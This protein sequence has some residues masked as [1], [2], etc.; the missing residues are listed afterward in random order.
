MLS[1]SN[2]SDLRVQTF[3]N[4]I[5]KMYLH[6]ESLVRIAP[7]MIAKAN[8]FKPMNTNENITTHLAHFMMNWN[9]L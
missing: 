1:E 8:Y 9:Y 4:C 3:P 6:D 5:V 7:K 2:G